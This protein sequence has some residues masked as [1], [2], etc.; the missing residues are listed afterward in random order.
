MKTDS[1]G[2]LQPKDLVEMQ[3]AMVRKGVSASDVYATVELNDE[4]EP[5]YA[6]WF[7]DV[8]ENESGDPVFS[9]LGYED[10]EKLLEDVRA[11]GITD[12]DVL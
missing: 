10:K 7:V 3:E 12:V 6:G 2:G 9:S 8:K 1:F 4:D 11:L 5:P